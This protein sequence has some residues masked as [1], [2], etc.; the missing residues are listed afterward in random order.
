MTS[1]LICS[2]HFSINYNKIKPNSTFLF[3]YSI[4]SFVK[5][6][7]L[8]FFFTRFRYNKRAIKWHHTTP[9]HTNTKGV[10]IY[11]E[12]PLERL[13]ICLH[14]NNGEVP[15]RR[16]AAQGRSTRVG[17]A[18]GDQHRDLDRC[19]AADADPRSRVVATE[20]SQ[21]LAQR[22]VSGPKGH[23]PAKLHHHLHGRRR[24]CAW[25]RRWRSPVT[26][27]ASSQE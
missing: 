19:D 16:G 18:C 4:P 15:G 7:F 11:S 27:G 26:S 9:H 3:L 8:L 10:V 21:D 23:A 14:D 24:G 6:T 1:I 25:G 12:N 20:T 22:S 17:S 2:K 13:E 5:D